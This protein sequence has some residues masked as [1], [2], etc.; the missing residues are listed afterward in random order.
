MAASD[1]KTRDHTG[2]SRS[3]LIIGLIVLSLI[4]VLGL[5]WQAH[6]ATTTHLKTATNVLR[7]YAT[8]V[9]DEYARRAMADV[10][11]YGYYTYVNLLR[12]QASRTARLPFEVIE[13][14]GDSP[15][16]RA[17]DD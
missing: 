7:E 8:L 2:S 9:A 16:A 13:P 10:G 1:R 14:A 12:Q 5:A 15:A 6:Q 4:L 3:R 11:Y 17:A